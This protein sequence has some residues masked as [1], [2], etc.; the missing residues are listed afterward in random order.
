MTKI[1]DK[2]KTNLIGRW[3]LNGSIANQG[4][5]GSDGTFIGTPNWGNSK[6]GRAL[7][8][9]GTNDAVSI[10]TSLDWSGASTIFGWFKTNY[11][12]A[13]HTVFASSV[14]GTNAM[15]IQ[16]LS[17]GYLGGMYYDGTIRDASYDVDLSDGK[18]HFFTWTKATGAVSPT[19]FVDGVKGTGTDNG[20]INGTAGMFIGQR[21]TGV[22]RFNGLQT[23][24]GVLNTNLTDAEAS[25][26]YIEITQE[27]HYDRVDIKHLKY[28]VD[29]DEIITNGDFSGGTT[30]WVNEGAIADTFEVAGG[31]LHVGDPTTTFY[32]SQWNVIL[33]SKKYTLTFD[34]DNVV[35]N[36]CI[37]RLYDFSTS[38]YIIIETTPALGSGTGT[39]VFDTYS[40]PQIHH[41]LYFSDVGGNTEY[42]IDNVSL[43]EVDVTKDVYIADGTGWN[44][45]IANETSG[46]L[47]NTG[48]S[49][50]SGTWQVD[51][52]KQKVFNPNLTVNGTFDTD[53]TWSKGTGWTISAGTANCDGSQVANSNLN[54]NNSIEVGK[55]YEIIFTV[56]N[57]SAGTIR[58]SLGGYNYAST[59][60]SN[61]TF[62]E[63]LTVTNPSSNNQIY[64]TANA[65]FIGS[66]DNVSV[67]EV[68]SDGKKQLT[69]VVSGRLSKY[70]TQAYGT[71]EFDIKVA[72]I[73]TTRVPF[74]ISSTAAIDTPTGYYFE[75]LSTGM[76]RFRKS[77]GGG[78]TELFTT[79]AGAL[80]SNN[81]YRIKITRTTAGA[82]NVYYSTDS[83]ETYTLFTANTGA[84]P[85]TNND[86]TTSF[87]NTFEANAADT[88][89]NFRFIPYIE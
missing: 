19:I 25:Q 85:E 12:T 4:G 45:S 16:I 56:S 22:E 51:D 58:C 80:I 48:W 59:R 62:K 32:I 46:F 77:T 73:G 43:K 78:S 20:S 11:K 65:D 1:L 44:E 71:W 89:R 21:T 36:P 79:V 74:A 68:K 75:V 17:S 34:Y 76:V 88:I 50:T 61:G 49:V 67:R 18:W 39:F 42:Y 10:G 64:F 41:K 35:G 63:L 52:S 47:S 15:S 2:Y 27:G 83:G 28:S 53:T 84:N 13:S 24:V 37:V 33:P 26:L 69:N 7:T 38:S 8:F 29:T 70:S 6:K 55:T 57:Y 86:Y 31:R 40:Y 30:S 3:L 9:D 82:F 81:W 5:S 87:Y 60:S 66:I 14:D 72:G 54:Q 23:K